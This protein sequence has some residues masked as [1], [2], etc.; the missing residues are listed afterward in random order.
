MR[1]LFDT[2]NLQKQ[3]F[4]ILSYI[5]YNY[6]T[7]FY[8]GVGITSIVI[9]SYVIYYYLNQSKP[10][11]KGDNE[12]LVSSVHHEAPFNPYL[13][14]WYAKD[15]P[16]PIP[17]E[18]I[19]LNEANAPSVASD[20][21][22]RVNTNNPTKYDDLYE[23]NTDFG[24]SIQNRFSHLSEYFK[25]VF[26]SKELPK[27]ENIP[28]IMITPPFEELNQNEVT[29][30]IVDVNIDTSPLVTANE[31]EV[32]TMSKP[33]M[34]DASVNTE[35]ISTSEVAVNTENVLAESPSNF[36]PEDTKGLKVI[37]N[38]I[39]PR[40][41]EETVD[42]PYVMA[43]WRKYIRNFFDRGTSPSLPINENLSTNQTSL[44]T[45]SASTVS[46]STPI[47]NVTSFEEVK[48][49]PK[50]TSDANVGTSTVTFT[51]ANVNTTPKLTVDVNVGTNT[52]FVDAN[53]GTSPILTENIIPTLT[54]DIIPN[55]DSLLN[56]IPLSEETIK[57]NVDK[58]FANIDS[59][60]FNE[61]DKEIYEAFVDLFN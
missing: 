51:D 2:L 41:I 1:N 49:I 6:V 19:D 31:L 56:I 46:N 47:V 23:S 13:K 15:I 35:S 5:D 25:S 39:T 54:E 50:L 45:E 30:P 12:G 27:F 7:G 3:N 43:N 8:W 28:Q 57:S 24:Q 38:N 60:L 14:Y 26:R 34:I 42:T 22:I 58:V 37:T 4:S 52:T 29:S 48:T 33:E 61:E 59:I 32:I 18:E 40:F 21:T 11:D 20:D 44:V 10:G 55:S 16:D 9:S 36:L 53:V 17:N